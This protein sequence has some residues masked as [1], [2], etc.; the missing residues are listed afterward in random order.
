MSGGQSRP[1]MIYIGVSAGGTAACS[2]APVIPARRWQKPSRHCRAAPTPDESI[3]PVSV[4]SSHLGGSHGG[5]SNCSPIHVPRR[6]R[7]GR[8]GVARDNVLLKQG[9]LEPKA[10][11]HGSS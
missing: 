8:S 2:T 11:R 6:L 4:T 7:V 10:R 1:T 3:L 9:N 5:C